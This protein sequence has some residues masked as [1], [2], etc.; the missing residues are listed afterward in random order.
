[1]VGSAAVIGL[2][3]L[4]TRTRCTLERRM[5]WTMGMQ[6]ESIGMAV[7]GECC[8]ASGFKE[9]SGPRPRHSRFLILRLFRLFAVC[10][11]RLLPSSLC[12]TWPDRSAR[13]GPKAPRTN[14]RCASLC[15]R[16]AA[17]RLSPL[18]LDLVSGPTDLCSHSLSVSPEPS[19]TLAGQMFLAAARSSFSSSTL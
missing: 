2:D 6:H 8:E 4:S 5:G 7:G 11:F 14:E 3:D 19:L 10:L 13:R 18:R 9:G 1:M 12:S 17:I 16:A 15:H